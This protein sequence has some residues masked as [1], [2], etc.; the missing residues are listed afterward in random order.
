MRNRILPQKNHN[1]LNSTDISSIPFSPP[2]IWMRLI[3]YLLE[4]EAWYRE[5]IAFGDLGVE[6]K[7]PD[8]EELL[9]DSD[10]YLLETTALRLRENLQIR[11]LCT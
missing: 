8:I 2:I 5:A 4:K 6:S 1:S 7:E 11:Y 3:A 9:G 10:R